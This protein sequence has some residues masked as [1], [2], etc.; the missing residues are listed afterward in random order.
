MLRPL[1]RWRDHRDERHA[2]RIRAD[3]GRDRQLVSWLPSG[4]GW[5]ARLSCPE[6]SETVEA[7][8]PTRRAAI[9][10]AAERLRRRRD[11]AR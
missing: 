9:A 1:L 8:G 4:R 5:M 6:V 11:A 2:R 3:L 10:R 7:H